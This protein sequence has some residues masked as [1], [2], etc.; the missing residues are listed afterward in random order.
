MVLNELQVKQILD[1]FKFI[2]GIKEEVKKHNS[3]MTNSFKE[4][5]KALDIDKSVITDTYKKWED[6]QGNEKLDTIILLYQ[7][8]KNS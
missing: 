4:L 3:T 1:V 2:K 6:A 5:A 7:A 8:L